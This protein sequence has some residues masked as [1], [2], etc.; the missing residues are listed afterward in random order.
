MPSDVASRV[1][2]RPTYQNPCMKR[3]GYVLSTSLLPGLSPFCKLNL[4]LC[5][6]HLTNAWKRPAASSISVNS[7]ESRHTP[8]CGHL[9]SVTYTRRCNG[10][11]APT[12]N[13]KITSSPV[14]SR[15]FRPG[16]QT[17]AISFN[18]RPSASLVK[19]APPRL[20]LPIPTSLH[21]PP[22]C[23]SSLSRRSKSWIHACPS[24]KSE[25]RRI[26]VRT[27]KTP[28]PSTLSG[29]DSD[30][31]TEG[32]SSLTVCRGSCCCCCCCCNGS[33]ATSSG[34]WWKR[35]SKSFGPDMSKA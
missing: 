22:F 34:V 12:L 25:A 2:S 7:P 4:L 16:G 11:G 23:G 18:T 10:P 9:A 20:L 24:T 31:D 14:G 19:E 17:F 28:S 8:W 33:S 29:A 5:L 32:A 35:N 27:H 26:G 1:W 3:H 15:S 21:P 30:D 6:G 13:Q